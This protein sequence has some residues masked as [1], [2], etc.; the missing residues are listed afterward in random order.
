MNQGAEKIRVH[1]TSKYESRLMPQGLS[2]RF[3][4]L[5]WP[6][7][8]QGRVQWTAIRTRTAQVSI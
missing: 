8:R 3:A 4:A 5:T 7:P 6:L 2:D 1:L